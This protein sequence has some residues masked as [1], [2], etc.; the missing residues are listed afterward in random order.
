LGISHIE[1]PATPDRIWTAIQE[2]KGHR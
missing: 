2:A 1:M